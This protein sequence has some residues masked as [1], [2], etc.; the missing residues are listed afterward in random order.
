MTQLICDVCGKIINA[1]YSCINFPSKFSGNIIQS[2]DEDDA[3]DVCQ[4]CA[5]EYY[6]L[7]EKFR[8]DKRDGENND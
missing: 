8:K 4:N 2:Y 3:S 7:T 6:N 5:L 1:T